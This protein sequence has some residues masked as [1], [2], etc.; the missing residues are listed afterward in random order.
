[1]NRLR[2]IAG[3]LQAPHKLQRMANFA[4]PIVLVGMVILVPFL[5]KKSYDEYR[6][7]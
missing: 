1:M 6:V 7:K 5:V 2:K 4:W 3:T